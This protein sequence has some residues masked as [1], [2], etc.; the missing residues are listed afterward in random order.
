MIDERMARLLLKLR[1]GGVTDTSVLK[2]IE[3]MPREIFLAGP[4]KSRSYE[5][6][7]LPIG[8]NQ[9]V[10]QPLIVALMTQ[11]LEVT[12][13][14]KV[15]EIG[16]G[17]GYQS[18]VLATLCRR[19]Y[20]IE[21]HPALSYQAEERF[22]KLGITNI[23]TLVGDGSLGWPSQA[24]FERI[25]VTAAARDV[26]LLLLKQLSIGGK[27]IIPIGVSDED[28]RLTKI[29]RT[30]SGAETFDL[31]PVKFVPLIAD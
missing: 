11:A 22:K 1:Q 16:T 27:M 19:V 5:N 14:T 13:R 4:F 12:T 20:T 6:V 25:I 17:S 8:H 21:R 9:T 29:T 3:K 24:P 26:P 23:T 15:L 7:A 28:Q 31:G 30:N 10:S 18:V 2:V